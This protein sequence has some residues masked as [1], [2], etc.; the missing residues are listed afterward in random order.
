M[1]A[2]ILGGSHSKSRID[3]GP[4]AQD[5]PDALA[6]ALS[7]TGGGVASAA[8]AARL[9]DDEIALARAHRT[10]QFIRCSKEFFPAMRDLADHPGWEIM[11][12]IFIAG[13]H[14]RAMTIAELCDRTGI[15]RPLAIRYVGILCERG[16]IDR[17]MSA[18]PPDTWALTLTP[19]TEARLQELLCGVWSGFQRQGEADAAN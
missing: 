4:Q 5:A 3:A 18:D 12:H 19:A 8:P 6:Q 14:G 17:D 16:L 7:G 10:L 13:R 2:G 15:W 11:L 9:S 1:F